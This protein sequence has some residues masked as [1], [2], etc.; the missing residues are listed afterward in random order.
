MARPLPHQA[1]CL[2]EGDIAQGVF[3]WLMGL[4]PDMFS[5]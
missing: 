3:E 2:V 1:S 4:V 5:A